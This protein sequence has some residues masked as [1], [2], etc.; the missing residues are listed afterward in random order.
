MAQDNSTGQPFGVGAMIGETFSILFGNFWLF[1][2]LSMGP[3]LLGALGMLGVF[4]SFWLE[5]NWDGASQAE[6]LEPDPKLS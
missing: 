4:G 1:L 6:N 5:A 2:I 3:I